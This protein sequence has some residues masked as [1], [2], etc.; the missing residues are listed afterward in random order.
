MKKKYFAIIIS[1]IVIVLGSQFLN[2]IIGTMYIINIIMSI[3][4]CTMLLMIALTLNRFIDRTI[5]QSTIFKTEAK[6]YVFYWLLLI[7]M[8]ATFVLFVYSGE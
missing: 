6:K 1:Y 2:F 3:V 8:L 7:C 4:I 5:K